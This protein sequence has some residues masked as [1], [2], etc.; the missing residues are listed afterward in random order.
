MSRVVWVSGASSG[1]GGA[2]A[3]A[4]PY[5]DARLIGISRR[6]S[7][8][9]ET[10]AADLGDASSWPTVA[11]HFR[12][13]LATAPEHA[14]FFH[15]AG[16]EIPVGP[17][18]EVDN[19]AYAAAVLVNSASGQVLGQ[20]FIAACHQAGVPATLILCSSPA[21]AIPT[22]G[23]SHYS[24]GKV[25]IER[26]VQGAV[27]EQEHHS[28]DVAIWGVVPFAVDTPMVRNQGEAPREDVPLSGLLHDAMERGVLASPESVAAEIW[29]AI[30]EGVEP[31]T[32]VHVGAVHAHEPSP[33]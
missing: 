25:A 29:A 27:L 33:S 20:A 30:D 1:I 2:F 22:P 28:T 14:L 7:E 23:L 13:V 3:R 31:G 5:D 16:T 32:F 26:W 21:A 10:F 6:Q 19:D 9:G 11:E 4:I 18:V 8:R 15:C 12:E 24:S 17:L